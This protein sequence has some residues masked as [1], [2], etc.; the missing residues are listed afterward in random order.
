MGENMSN[1]EQF[2]FESTDKMFDLAEHE[3]WKGKEHSFQ[4]AVFTTLRKVT[5]DEVKT[6]F[7]E[8]GKHRNERC[9]VCGKTTRIY[10][11]QIHKTLAQDLVKLWEHN[12]TELFHYAEWQRE[13]GAMNTSIASLRHW[14]LVEAPGFSTDDTEADKKDRSGEWR[15]TPKGERF[16]RGHEEVYEYAHIGPH[17]VFEG[18]SGPLISIGDIW[19]HFDIEKLL[20][21]KRPEDP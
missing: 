11:N 6:W 9:V 13:T 2:Q 3:K 10:R 1:A 18:F 12:G 21:K 20:E 4:I 8:I 5:L 14:G 19:E 17:A 7:N 15:I 16:I